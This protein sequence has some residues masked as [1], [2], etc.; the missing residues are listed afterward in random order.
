[1]NGDLG[2]LAHREIPPPTTSLPP[3]DGFLATSRPGA[4]TSH[5]PSPPCCPLAQVATRSHRPK[6]GWKTF[7][8]LSLS[9]PS[10]GLG[11]NRDAR[12]RLCLR[13]GHGGS[14][15][16][17]DSRQPGR[18]EPLSYL[19]SRYQTL[20]SMKV[21][22]SLGTPV[23]SELGLWNWEKRRLV[24]MTPW[25]LAG[26]DPGSWWAPLP[27]N[28]VPRHLGEFMLTKGV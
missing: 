25:C 15:P 7:I 8:L 18:C 19:Q 26:G 20:P 2:A 10:E 12:T 3:W 23:T 22:I 4:L 16:H 27:S 14:C 24:F 13:A 11:M 6:I 21:A 5:Q 1:M 28:R 9:V 17:P